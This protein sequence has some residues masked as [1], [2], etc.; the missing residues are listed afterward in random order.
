MQVVADGWSKKKRDQQVDAEGLCLGP[1][2]VGRQ[3]S[4]PSASLSGKTSVGKEISVSKENVGRERF[5]CGVELLVG[6]YMS[7]EKGLC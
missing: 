2:K 5:T 7:V 4:T 6:K 1:Q 3:K